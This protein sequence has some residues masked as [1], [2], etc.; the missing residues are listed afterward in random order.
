[1]ELLKLQRG[2]VRAWQHAHS[3]NAS[4]RSERD[5]RILMLRLVG[6]GIVD[7]DMKTEIQEYRG[8]IL[9]ALD[10]NPQLMEPIVSFSH[11]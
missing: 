6:R 8:I 5:F 9:H 11:T 7:L 4:T 2:H 10:K 1:M 3:T